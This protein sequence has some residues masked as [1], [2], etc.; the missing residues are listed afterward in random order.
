MK[1]YMENLLNKILEDCDSDIR[2]WMLADSTTSKRF[3]ELEVYLNAT[4]E[5]GYYKNW[6]VVEQPAL[7]ALHWQQVRNAKK[8]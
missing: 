4:P 2:E 3:I 6:Q 8:I 1:N 5:K 7:V